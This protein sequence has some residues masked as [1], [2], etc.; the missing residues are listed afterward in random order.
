MA[1]ELLC[2]EERAREDVN[3]SSGEVGG[4]GG[5]MDAKEGDDDGFGLG[6]E[7]GEGGL[8]NGANSGKLVDRTELTMGSTPL[9]LAA[10]RLESRHV[11]IDHLQ[12]FVRVTLTCSIL[13][14]SPI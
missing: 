5:G 10:V 2:F 8:G 9:H 3:S 7:G 6:G 14:C 4:T 13:L 12:A 1:R 11:R